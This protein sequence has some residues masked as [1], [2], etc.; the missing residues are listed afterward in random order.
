VDT[1]TGLLDVVNEDF[2]TRA[3]AS[4]TPW[5]LPTPFTMSV[6]FAHIF[7]S[8]KKEGG[9]NWSGALCAEVHI[10]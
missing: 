3:Q 8:T 6:F 1:E 10:L 5:P 4:G 7:N 2:M 9:W